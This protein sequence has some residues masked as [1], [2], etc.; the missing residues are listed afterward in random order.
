MAKKKFKFGE[1]KK[2]LKMLDPTTEVFTF[3]C[4]HPDRSRTPSGIIQGTF[5]E[6]Q[7]AL[8]DYNSAGYGVYV[9][10]NACDGKGR[11]IKNIK[12]IRAAW[13]EDDDGFEGKL[14]MKP[15]II[16]LTS[17]DKYHRYILTDI[18][19]T[20][21]VDKDEFDKI[22]RTLVDKYGSDNNARDITR[23]LRLPGFFNTK[24]SLKEPFLVTIEGGTGKRHPWKKLVKKIGYT[25][26][27]ARE[28]G[29]SG[30]K[31]GGSGKKGEKFTG[32]EVWKNEPKTEHSIIDIATAKNYYQPMLGW[33]MAKVNQGI[34][35]R[36]IREMLLT[37]FDLAKVARPD[38]DTAIWAERVSGI[39]QIINSALAKK[40]EE[41]GAD[42]FEDFVEGEMEDI[43]WMWQDILPRGKVTIFAGDGGS[44][45]TLFVG[46]LAARIS[47]GKCP[48]FSE[49]PFKKGKTVIIT[50][51]DDMKDTLAPR[52][53]AAGGKEG[54]LK[55][56]NLQSQHVDL[57]NDSEL[58]LRQLAKIK[59]LQ[60]LIIDPI[61]TFQGDIKGHNAGEIAQ[62]MG[63]I[64]VIAEQLN[65]G[66]V[67]IMHLNKG[68]YANS[69]DKIAGSKAY[70]N[71]VRSAVMFHR[72]LELNKDI[73]DSIVYFG[74]VKSN[75]SPNAGVIEYKIE[76]VKVKGLKGKQPKIQILDTHPGRRIEGFMIDVKAKTANSKVDRATR[77][78]D[79]YIKVA[80]VLLSKL[81]I[82]KDGSL[83]KGVEMDDKSFDE[84]IVVGVTEFRKQVKQYSGFTDKVLSDTEM[85]RADKS[86]GLTYIIAQR[87]RGYSAK[88]LV[89]MINS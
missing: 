89:D 25:N 79:T 70:I 82:K 67:C 49:K 39:D 21:K 4:F 15:S 28:K 71:S 56:W 53:H 84:D 7:D 60:L 69:V 66:V 78:S 72:N 76:A 12:F 31:A 14:P 63:K 16:I 75:L 74:Q 32:S 22:Q 37:A 41:E 51:E 10:I 5:E 18:I 1:A 81:G 80:Q 57:S 40:D 19:S 26:G 17:P 11:K 55:K 33:T 23:V 24:K 8:A 46:D 20:K 83:K 52:F 13:Q 38:Q 44:G 2:F 85:R 6:H 48:P 87:K 59:G 30:S 47:R 73:N 61:A 29:N 42:L 65:I 54:Y 27:D 45:K 58:V 50:A 9:T 62:V 86:L 77:I 64:A 43:D 3:Q 34:D 68:D 36:S 88:S 35:E